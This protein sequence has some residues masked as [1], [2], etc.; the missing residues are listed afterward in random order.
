M[1]RPTATGLKGHV[2]RHARSRTDPGEISAI[3]T[4]H[5]I[6]MPRCD[7]YMHTVTFN[8]H[9]LPSRKRARITS[10]TSY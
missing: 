7:V 8:L 10:N 9:V 4:Q 1:G 2:A 3:V 6:R 5:F